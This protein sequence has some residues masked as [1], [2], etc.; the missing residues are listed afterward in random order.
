MLAESAIYNSPDYQKYLIDRGIDQADKWGP[1]ALI[2]IGFVAILGLGVW[3]FI[4]Y[5]NNVN[6]NA[7]LPTQDQEKKISDQSK[8]IETLFRIN[9]E[10]KQQYNDFRVEVAKDIGKM[11]KEFEKRVSYAFMDSQLM[12]KIDLMCDRM[13]RIE[14]KI[15]I[16]KV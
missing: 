11:E 6:K 12:P 2:A 3:G 4:K 16:N 5:A 10:L 7:V 1:M 13:A 8:N 14:Q 15:G 9:S